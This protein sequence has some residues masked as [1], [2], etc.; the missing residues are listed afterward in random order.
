MS[1][2]LQVRHLCS[3]TW[4][5]MYIRFSRCILTFLYFQSDILFVEMFY[6]VLKLFYIGIFTIYRVWHF[7]SDLFYG[8]IWIQARKQ[9]IKYQECLLCK[10]CK[11]CFCHIYICINVDLYVCM[12]V[13]MHACM[14]LCVYLYCLHANVHVY[15][16]I[17]KR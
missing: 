9:G 11:T 13:S 16:L 10:D 14:Y 1:V 8:D 17:L 15:V 5:S 2:R 7:F 3:I 4:N 6:I 12:Y